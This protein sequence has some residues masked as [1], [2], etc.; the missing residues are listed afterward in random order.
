MPINAKYLFVSSMDVDA[1]KDA[2]F[3]EV[4]DDEHVPALSKVP[5][6]LSI[7]RLRKRTLQLSIGGRV[8]TFEAEGEPHYSAMYEVASPEVLTSDAWANAIEQGRWPTD[9]RP[10]AKNTRRVLYELIY[11]TGAAG[12]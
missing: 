4:Y 3:N 10:V 6:V 9:V 5:G 8:Q 12:R 1:D 2:L 7:A 11:S